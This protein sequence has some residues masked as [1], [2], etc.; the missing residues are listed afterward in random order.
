MLAR[1]R[2]GEHGGGVDFASGGLEEAGHGEVVAGEVP[3]VIEGGGVVLCVRETAMKFSG[4]FDSPLGDWRG[5]GEAYRSEGG[6]W[7]WLEFDSGEGSEWLGAG[8]GG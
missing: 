8:A 3:V 5:K 2:A 7:C 4:W 6:R 1:A